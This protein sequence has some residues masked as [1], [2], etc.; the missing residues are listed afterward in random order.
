MQINEIM[1]KIT[2]SL[3]DSILAKIRE[4]LEAEKGPNSIR[5]KNIKELGEILEENGKKLEEIKLKGQEHAEE[6]CELNLQFYSQA[7][8]MKKQIRELKDS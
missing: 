1:A 8:V 7:K 5:T 4:T 3:S 6:Y 2:K